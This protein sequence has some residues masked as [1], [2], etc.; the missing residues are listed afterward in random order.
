MT[1]H[2][3]EACRLYRQHLANIDAHSERIAR[4][5]ADKETRD[6]DDTEYRSWVTSPATPTEGD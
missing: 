4:E 1:E 3:E 2:L 6:N 5:I